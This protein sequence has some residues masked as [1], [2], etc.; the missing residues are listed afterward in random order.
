MPCREFKDFPNY[1]TLETK[2]TARQANL[3]DQ[4]A[5]WVVSQHVEKLSGAVLGQT[6]RM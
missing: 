1:N 6:G 5:S 2:Y 4:L 3:L